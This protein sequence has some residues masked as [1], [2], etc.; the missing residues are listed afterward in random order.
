M[1]SKANHITGT[2]PKMLQNGE[3]QLWLHMQLHYAVSIIKHFQLWIISLEEKCCWACYSMPKMLLSFQYI[4]I[5]VIW[6]NSTNVLWLNVILFLFS[7]SHKHCFLYIYPNL[8]QYT[9]FILKSNYQP[10]F[11]FWAGKILMD[12]RRCEG[13]LYKRWP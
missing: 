9:N 6:L 12:H 11:V 1:G 4:H 13:Q 10:W 3:M 2:I 7:W 8:P 5:N